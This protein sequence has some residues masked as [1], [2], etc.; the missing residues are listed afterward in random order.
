MIPVL[1]TVILLSYTKLLRTVILIFSIS[2]LKC[3][4]KTLMYWY[5]DP[6]QRYLHSPQHI[7]LFMMA[8]L[9]MVFLIFPFTVFLLLY[10]LLEMS[11]EKCRQKFSW[12]LFKLKPFFD[13]YRAPYTN[14][15]CFWPG[16]LL[17]VRIG[18]ALSVALSRDQPCIPLACLFVTLVLLISIFSIGIIYKS[19]SR[20]PLLDATFLA[21]LLFVTY[22]LNNTHGDEAKNRKKAKNGTIS[23]VS[24]VFIVFLA[25]VIY[26]LWKYTRRVRQCKCINTSSNDGVMDVNSSMEGNKNGSRRSLP[27]LSMSEGTMR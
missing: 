12:F 9:V 22:F 18:L 6:T 10:P 17:L 21:A 1:A 13:S 24:F 20:L 11:P 3:D 14:L 26:H 23:I 8:L 7:L 2:H 19:E 16:A 25:I 27:R 15:F 5:V 4:T